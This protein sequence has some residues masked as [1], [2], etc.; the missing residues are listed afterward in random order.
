M[1]LSLAAMQQLLYET[2]M[3]WWGPLP[4]DDSLA[5]RAFTVKS[6]WRAACVVAALPGITADTFG[7]LLMELGL[8]PYE[9]VERPVRGIKELR[10]NYS[11]PGR[12]R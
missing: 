12:T 11:R 7:E 2:A 4:E 6:P 3:E 5:V 9:S 8:L 10:S 1:T